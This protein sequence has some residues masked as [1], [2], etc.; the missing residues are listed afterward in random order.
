MFILALVGTGY[1]LNAT[2]KQPPL[3]AYPSPSAIGRLFGFVHLGHE[4]GILNP[5]KRRNNGTNGK[6][7]WK[8]RKEEL[9][10]IFTIPS[11]RTFPYAPWF[12]IRIRT[13]TIVRNMAL[14]RFAR[15]AW[16]VLGYNLLVIGWGAYV[17]AS[18]SGAGCGNHWPL[19]KG[20]VLPRTPALETLVELTHRLTSGL[21][22]IFVLGLVV[23]AFRRFPRNHHV[24]VSALISLFF[25]LTEALIGAGLVLFEY[26]ATNASHARAFWMSGHLINTFL[27]L[28]A[29]ALTAWWA[30]GNQ[31]QPGRFKGRMGRQFA[32]ALIGM[33]IL[34]V[35]GAI[36]ALGDT[37]FP[38]GSLAAGLRQDL[39]PAAHIFLRLRLW[40]PLIALVVGVGTWWLAW[41]VRKSPPQPMVMK[42]SVLLSALVA[43]QLTAGATN[44]LLLAPIWMQLIHLLLSDLLWIVLVL[45]S[46]TRR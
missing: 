2:A 5:C 43:I 45:L 8:L 24:R 22:L 41:K 11:F 9:T 13:A 38:A 14:T 46:A 30:S 10:A 37:L 18:G 42:L 35:S 3:E 21:A 25:I 40:H 34:G 7:E 31:K 15:Y 12:P 27:L 16:F 17:R 44:L 36:T 6:E 4:R 20:E 23:W 39:S 33:M 29:I 32:I 1:L 19:C 28:G 26:V